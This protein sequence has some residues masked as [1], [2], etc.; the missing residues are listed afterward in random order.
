MVAISTTTQSLRVSCMT[1]NNQ[2]LKEIQR[3]SEMWE[4]YL[5]QIEW[6]GEL[7]RGLVSFVE[8]GFDKWVEK[9][10]DGR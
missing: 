3:K 4:G 9:N 6:A 8:R 5:E 7:E 2:S 1:L 10:R